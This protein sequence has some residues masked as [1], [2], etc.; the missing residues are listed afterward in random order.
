MQFIHGHIMG[1]HVPELEKVILNLMIV[2]TNR[3]KQHY[4]VVVSMDTTDA[5]AF[6]HQILLSLECSCLLFP[7]YYSS[8]VVPVSP[9]A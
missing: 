4:Y 3:S 8:L 6:R 1:K 5:F 2:L 9:S 7:C